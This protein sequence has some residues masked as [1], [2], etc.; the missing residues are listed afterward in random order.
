MAIPSILLQLARNNPKMMQLKQIMNA[1]RT[2][3]NPNEMINTFLMNNPDMKNVMQTINQFGGDPQKAFY[4]MAEKM[5][6]NPQDVLDML[7]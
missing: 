5:G 3:Q 6:V 7:K 4:G 1:V 2:S